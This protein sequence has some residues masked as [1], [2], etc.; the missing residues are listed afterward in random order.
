MSGEYIN[1]ENKKLLTRG[2]CFFLFTAICGYLSII[3]SFSPY[4]DD[5]PRYLTNYPVG[6][7]F[8]GRIGTRI[9]ELLSF[10]SLYSYD[11]APFSTV[12]SCG[13]L[14]AAAIIFKQ[15]LDILYHKEYASDKFAFACLVP[16]VVNPYLAE[17]FIFRF[18]N[19]FMTLAVLCAVGAAY[20][21]IIINHRN[22]N[23]VGEAAQWPLCDMSM[24]KQVS[25][26]FCLLLCSLTLYQAA[27]SA[28][29]LI[30][31]YVLLV[32]L[33]RDK[34]LR[35]IVA[36]MRQW[37]C[38]LLLAVIS[39]IPLLLHKNPMSVARPFGELVPASIDS[40][41]NNCHGN[42]CNYF[43]GL[44]AD[45]LHN[46]AGIIFFLLSLGFAITFA[47]DAWRNIKNK[48]I[49]ITR[50]ALIGICVFAFF[51][52]P[53][54]ANIP[55]ELC[56]HKVGG[57]IKPRVLYCMGILMAF[58]LYKNYLFICEALARSAAAGR[59]VTKYL[60]SCCRCY[61][62]FLFFFGLWNI[63][64]MNCFG[65]MMYMQRLLQN[66]VFYDLA[67]DIHA[68][69]QNDPKLS[70]LYMT[71]NISTPVLQNFYSL[72]PINNKILPET[73]SVAI[74]CMFG[75]Y[76][77]GIKNDSL[78]CIIVEDSDWRKNSLLLK[79]KPWYDI[80][81]VN[82]NVLFVELNGITTIGKNANQLD[83]NSYIVFPLTTQP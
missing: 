16:I 50:I 72:Y 55:L 36:E 1:A 79:S 73:W 76:Y 22:D 2:F 27:L 43:S 28:Y 75:F 19:P 81:S 66:N 59:G 14:A 47:I 25:I 34:P 53:L 13:F 49:A 18:D 31:L 23:D 40:F 44:Y 56:S 67:N 57:C 30:F 4:N 60:G 7:C 51:I 37:V 21:S 54:G 77:K 61:R 78:K 29:I 33:S 64:Y 83:P 48:P 70:L 9:L 63:G 3:T 20:F 82:D 35:K 6:V 5:F 41:I 11:A 42:I 10:L 12:L 65:N 46:P 69:K 62:I 58:V 17:V 38:L 39:F 71:G 74:Y 32:N 68:L 24:A 26:Q 80:Y 52:G 8:Y 15:I 45:W